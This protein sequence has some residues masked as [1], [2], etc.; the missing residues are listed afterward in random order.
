MGLKRTIEEC[1]KAGESRRTRSL[2][3]ATKPTPPIPA[4]IWELG[5]GS[6]RRNA[7]AFRKAFRKPFTLGSKIPPPAKR[8]PGRTVKLQPLP[9][10]DKY[11]FAEKLR[12]KMTVAEKHLWRSL[13]GFHPLFECQVVVGGYIADF[14]CRRYRLIVEVDGRSHDGREAYDKT[15]DEHLSGIGY[16]TMRFTNTEVLATRHEVIEKIISK[17]GRFGK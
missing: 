3:S 16:R 14:C 8:A 12:E 7:K 4:S 9:K 15:R 5:P 2:E 6:A 1:R 13:Q 10:L 11:A 17:C